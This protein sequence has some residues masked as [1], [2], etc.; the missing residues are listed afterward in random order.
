VISRRCCTAAR[1]GRSAELLD[2]CLRV[3]LNWQ[4]MVMYD[5]FL[6]KREAKPDGVRSA[7]AKDRDRLIHSS[8]LRR[9]QG[10][11]Q[12]VGT[13][14]SDFFRTRLTHTLECA[15]IGRAIA[16]RIPDGSW[17]DEAESRDDFR[18]LVE[19]ACLAHDLGHPPFGHNGEEALEEALKE[20]S[21]SRFEGNAQS[22]RI[23]TFVEAKEF[24]LTAAGH[25]RWVG[26]NLTRATLR[27][28]CKYPVSERKPTP[29]GKFNVYDDPEDLEYFDWVWQSDERTPS[30]AA[31]IMDTS[32]DIAYGVHD[33]EDGVWAG[34]IPLYDLVA[35]REAPVDQLARKVL[36]R[37]ANRTE[38]A[39]PDED[40][41]GPLA[42]LL[43]Q[44]KDTD[45][46]GHP[47]ERTR[48]GR[49]EL[50]AFTAQLIHD[51]VHDVT[52]GGF[53]TPVGPVRQRLDI[54][55]GMA[56]V[57]MIERTDLATQRFG[58]RRI[59]KD[60][61]DGYWQEPAMLPRQDEWREVQET[62]ASRWGRWPEKARLIRD[63]IA[64]M[65]DTY[66]VEVHHEMYSGQDVMAISLTY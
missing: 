57:W 59:V 3:G 52:D 11:S 45:W 40:I 64:G 50:K 54:L 4:R 33:F 42:D 2:I 7:V 62:S 55:T 6:T 63:H 53:L 9:L 20:H 15:Q 25:D 56:W 8:A 12:I 37:D 31:A 23:V 36:E 41:A 43:H 65:T 10:K 24:G 51:L 46:A 18:D 58:Q 34:M 38:R 61:F 1:P 27:A 32:D 29:A 16:A 14:T 47:F 49:R 17:E 26:L 66:A 21:R 13:R 30:L 28:V 22:F 39:F 19:A 48:H 5:R 60:L 35:A 44:V